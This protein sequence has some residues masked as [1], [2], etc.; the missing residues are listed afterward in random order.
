M[1]IRTQ[2]E[3]VYK[4]Q[5]EAFAA[6]AEFQA[7]EQGRAAAAAY[8]QFLSDLCKAHIQS[9]KILA[10]LYSIAPPASSE[11]VKH[12]LLE[13]LGLEEAKESHPQILTKTMQ[14]A[15]FDATTLTHL[16]REAQEEVRHMCTDPFMYGTLKEFGLHI[17]LEV[18]SFEWMLSRLASRMGDFLVQHQRMRQEDLLWFFYHSEKDIQHAEE[19]LDTIVDYANYYGL[20]S[21]ELDA[22]LDITFRENVFLR[23]YFPG[24]VRG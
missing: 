10:F 3:S 19:A 15:G 21:E 16:E 8:R 14:A 7:L 13:E 9:P 4:A 6:S 12:N 20:S 5:T 1:N 17:L 18:S 24:G 23:R 22:I 11:H 2:V